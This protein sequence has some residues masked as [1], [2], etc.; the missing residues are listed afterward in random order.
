MCQA[1][2]GA[3]AVPQ[4]MPNSKP[5][6]ARPEPIHARSEA[7]NTPARARC[8][9]IPRS[10]YIYLGGVLCPKQTEIQTDIKQ[11]ALL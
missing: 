4:L 9:L 10:L 7:Q 8:A 5:K 6:H 3:G 1:R 11:L 2:P